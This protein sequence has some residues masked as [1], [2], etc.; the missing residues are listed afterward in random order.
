[1]KICW[2]LLEW[3]SIEKLSK[4]YRMFLIALEWKLKWLQEINYKANLQVKPERIVKFY[5]STQSSVVLE[6][7]KQFTFKSR[8]ERKQGREVLFTF[9]MSIITIICVIDFLWKQCSI[10]CGFSHRPTHF[11]HANA[12]LSSRLFF[13]LRQ[14]LSQADE[15][16]NKLSYFLERKKSP[17]MV[18]NFVASCFHFYLHCQWKYIFIAYIAYPHFL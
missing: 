18:N 16:R 8:A 15:N 7:L 3:I 17:L 10:G 11:S 1:M 13:L 9:L 4:W 6:Q 12:F 5:V 14:L 2:N